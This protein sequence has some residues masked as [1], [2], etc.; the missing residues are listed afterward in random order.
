MPEDHAEHNAGIPRKVRNDVFSALT[1]IGSFAGASSIVLMGAGFE[2]AGGMVALGTFLLLA[3]L[4]LIQS[5][6]GL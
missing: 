2:K 5:A 4:I 3:V 6:V 1:I